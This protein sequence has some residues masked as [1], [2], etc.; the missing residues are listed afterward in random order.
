MAR[1][2]NCGAWLDM[3]SLAD[4]KLKCKKCGFPN[5]KE[6]LKGK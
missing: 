6:M 4:G 1:C 5:P 3:A 2:P